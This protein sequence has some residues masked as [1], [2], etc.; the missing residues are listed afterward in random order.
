LESLEER[1]QKI[2]DLFND[3]YVLEAI[4]LTKQ[5]E[6]EI[7]QKTIKSTSNKDDGT[8]FRTD[9]FIMHVREDIMITDKC[10]ECLN[11][12]NTTK[13]NRSHNGVKTWFIEEPEMSTVTVCA[14]TTI[15][16]NLLQLCSVLAEIEDMPK[17]IKRF[18][19]LKK[20]CEVTPFRWMIKIR[21][22]MPMFID[23]R[24]VVGAGF[25]IMNEESNSI[26]LPFK[27]LN[28][29]NDY[30]GTQ[31]PAEE[32]SFKRIDMKFGYMHIIPKDE[33]SCEVSVAFNVDPKVPLIPWIILNKFIKEASYYIM[34][35]F[36]NQIEKLDKE[37][38]L[39]KI[40]EKKEFYTKVFTRLKVLQNNN[41]KL[42]ELV[43]K[44]L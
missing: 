17:Y 16:S 39:K 40:N 21:I 25:A 35:D 7:E 18:H 15:N 30:F 27:S 8:F 11:R 44:E 28:N 13:E 4:N 5:T 34:L 38:F 33:N 24:E 19:S 3:D 14:T 41:P 37:T 1:M 36:K 23:N 32:K 9:P 43:S 26:I 31:V 6:K 12:I 22:K 2:K 29:Q 10:F 20:V 42:F